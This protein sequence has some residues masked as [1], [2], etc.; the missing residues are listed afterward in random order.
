[1]NAL[2]KIL[3]VLLITFCIQATAQIREICILD[4]TAKNAEATR[5]NLFSLEHILKS[6]GFTYSIT[7]SVNLAIRHKVV[8]PTSNIEPT[9]FSQTERDS[10]RNYISKGG[11]LIATNIKDPLLYDCFG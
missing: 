5:G 6:A 11:T 3:S 2:T 9:T 1:M 10:I 4:L 8:L 7:D